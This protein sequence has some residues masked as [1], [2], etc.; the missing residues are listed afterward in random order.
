VVSLSVICNLT[1][2]L[3]DFKEELDLDANLKDYNN[4]GQLYEIKKR[5][6]DMKLIVFGENGSSWFSADYFGQT[7]PVIPE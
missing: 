7:V 5:I 6:W 2:S 4:E 1:V 3:F